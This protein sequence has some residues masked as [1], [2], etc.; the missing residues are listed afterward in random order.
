MFKVDI[1]WNNGSLRKSSRKALQINSKETIRKQQINNED[2]I[3]DNKDQEGPSKYNR[4]Q[5]NDNKD[6]MKK[7][8]ET[9][10]K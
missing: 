8:T 3:K 5:K 4:E 6:T 9:I 7:S 2:T 10:D 1:R